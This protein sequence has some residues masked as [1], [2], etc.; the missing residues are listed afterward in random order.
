MG[1]E[2]VEH[3]RIVKGGRFV[4]ELA[5]RRD[6]ESPTYD[7]RVDLCGQQ[8]CFVSLQIYILSHVGQTE[9]VHYRL[10]VLKPQA[11]IECVQFCAPKKL[12][13]WPR[14]EIASDQ[15]PDAELMSSA[16][17]MRVFLERGGEATAVKVI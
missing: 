8:V 10:S 7:A 4:R 12:S 1:A 17:A 9:H 15:T 2:I 13:S 11:L 16:S 6:L 3:W 14:R 5:S